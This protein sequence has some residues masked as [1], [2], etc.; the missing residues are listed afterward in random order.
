MDIIEAKAILNSVKE[1]YEFNNI[2][3]IGYNIL[4]IV[5]MTARQLSNTSLDITT[6]RYFNTEMFIYGT[7]C[8]NNSIINFTLQPDKSEEIDEYY[9]SN[10]KNYIYNMIVKF[11]TDEVVELVIGYSKYCTEKNIADRRYYTTL[12]KIIYEVY[13]E[14]QH[15]FK[16]LI[17]EMLRINTLEYIFNKF[18][19]LGFTDICAIVLDC[20]NRLKN[21]NDNISL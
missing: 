1:N 6:C 9:I 12:Y 8:I 7:I 4:G 5:Q 11:D 17:Q 14:N 18:L 10:L 3:I 16:Q 15:G 13:K 20:V 2:K 19:F 21:N